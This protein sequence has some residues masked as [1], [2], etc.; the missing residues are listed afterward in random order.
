[1]NTLKKLM[2]HINEIEAQREKR[3]NQPLPPNIIAAAARFLAL[4]NS[5]RKEKISRFSP[6]FLQNLRRQVDEAIR[7]AQETAQSYKSLGTSRE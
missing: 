1:M 3:Q 4:E 6:D 5:P 2:T 7:L